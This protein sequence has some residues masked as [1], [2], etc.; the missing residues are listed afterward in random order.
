MHFE[1]LG[2]I[3]TKKTRP[4]FTPEFR[5][6]S[7]QLVVEK[8]YSV[9]EAAEVMGLGNPRWINGCDSLELNAQAVML[10]RRRR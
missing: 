8:N 5:L 4:R 9:R 2:G 3:M 1:Q 7:A 10:G 6:E